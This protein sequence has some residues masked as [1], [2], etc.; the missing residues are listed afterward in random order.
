M[1]QGNNRGRRG[2]GEV[3]RVETRQSQRRQWPKKGPRTERS[4]SE[5]DTEGGGEAGTFQ[6]QSRLK[7]RHMTNIYSTDSDEEAIDEDYEELYDKTYEKFKDKVRDDG[8]WESFAISHNLS[9]K[10]CKT[11]FESQRTHYGKLTQSKSGQA[12]KEMT[13]RT[14]F[15]TNLAS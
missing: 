5:I 7:K 13:G 9:V 15:R 6:F 8:L 14:G 4:S 12:P 2:R 10:V 3:R 11:C 1:R